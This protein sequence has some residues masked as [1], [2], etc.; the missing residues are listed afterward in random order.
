MRQSSEIRTSD[1]RCEPES[2]GAF[3]TALAAES[4]KLARSPTARL[5]TVLLAV[6]VPVLAAG[7]VAAAERGGSSQLALKVRPL[8]HGTGWEALTSIS[9]QV[10]SISMLLGAGFVVSWTFGREFSEDTLE[11]LLMSRPSRSTLATAKI[12]AVLGWASAT[13]VTAALVT[14]GTGVRLGQPG[15]PWP[16]LARL[17]IGGLLSALLAVPFAFVA[18]VA[19]SALAG[20][21]AVIG[22]I[23][24]T[25]LLTVVGVGG[26]FPYAAPSLWLGMGGPAMSASPIQLVLVIPVGLAGWAATALWWQQVELTSS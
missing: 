8:V 17:A 6:A 1:A 24:V 18:T 25:Q 12:A 9:G 22:V 21:G 16:G 26:W 7:F 15:S 23:V 11:T 5:V 10:L 13:T 19:R 20:V 4:V 3:P 2:P 14:L